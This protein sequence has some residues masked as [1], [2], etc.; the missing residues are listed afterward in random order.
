ME[1]LTQLYW[2]ASQQPVA[3]RNRGVQLAYAAKELLD[4]HQLTPRDSIQALLASLG[5]SYAH[6][7]RL[8]Q[9]TF[10]QSPLAYVN[11]KKLERARLLLNDPRTTVQE[12]ADAA[13]YADVSYFIRSFRRH[14]GQTPGEYRDAK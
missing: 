11:A 14:F 6:Q 2:P 10:G 8:F 5:F 1:L 7:A 3:K 9:Q 13:G 12:A 4:Q